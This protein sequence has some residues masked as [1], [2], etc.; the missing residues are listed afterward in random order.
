MSQRTDWQAVLQRSREILAEYDTGVTLRQLFYRLVAASVLPNSQASYK[1]LSS[2]TAAAR[3]SGTFPSLIDPT[4][5]IDRLPSW[6]DPNEALAALAAQYRRPR[7]DGQAHSV[8]LGVE[9]RGIVAQLRAWF[10]EPL[11]LPILAL[12]GYASQS[13]VDEVRADL[14]Q[15]DRPAILLYG[16][17]FDPSGE[18][19]DRDFVDRV[20]GFADV[21]RIALVAD[22]IERYQLPPN[23]GKATDSRA[24]RFSERHGQLVQ[25]EL[26]ALDPSVLRTLYQDA[27]DDFWDTSAFHAVLEEETTERAELTSL[28]IGGPA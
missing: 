3:R 9:K 19:I 14:E 11:G 18:D 2:R 26:D 23:P 15:Q 24:Q 20:G 28:A 13:F 17:D 5:E 22:Q 1:T 10:G 16:G 12:G 7:W 4:R 27:I 6:P 25:V 8:Y 21:R